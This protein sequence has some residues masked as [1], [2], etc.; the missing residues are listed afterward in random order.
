MKQTRKMKGSFSQSRRKSMR[1]RQRSQK[2][3]MRT[4][5]KRN[6]YKK[7]AGGFSLGEVTRPDPMDVIYIYKYGETG[8][9]YKGKIVI[10]RGT[11]DNNYADDKMIDYT[12][13]DYRD[14]RVDRSRVPTEIT[15]RT[16]I[17]SYLIS[18]YLPDIIKIK[19]E[20]GMYPTTYKSVIN[21]IKE[22]MK[23]TSIKSSIETK[24][25]SVEDGLPVQ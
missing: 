25:S 14:S 5:K 18:N 6:T 10:T 13:H 17:L 23:G 16:Q 11:K 19:Y 7:R 2:K 1:M 22:Y 12:G 3:Q 24:C 8:P 15:G 20:K 21:N 4:Y 9:C